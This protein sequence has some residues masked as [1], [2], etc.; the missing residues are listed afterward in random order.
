MAHLLTVVHLINETEFDFCEQ[1]SN[2][3][4]LFKYTVG[5]RGM[6]QVW[7]PRYK[8]TADHNAYNLGL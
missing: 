4:P 6:V 2:S 5:S 7:A 1:G 3:G 8:K